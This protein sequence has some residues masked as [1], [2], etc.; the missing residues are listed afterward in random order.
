MAK[1]LEGLK[2]LDLSR[3]LAGPW[4]T[5]LLADMG[6][7]VWKVEKPGDGDDTRAWGPPYVEAADGMSRESAYFLCANRGKHSLAIDIA[8]PEGSALVARLAARADVLIENF[9]VGGLKRY[10]LDY[11]TLSAANPRLIY[12]SITGFGQDG[13]YAQRPGYDFVIQGMGGLMSVTGEAQGEPMKAGVAIVDVFTGLY[14]A[15]A[16]QAALLQRER[17]GRG[18]QIDIALLDV[19]VATLAN[20]AL[21]HLTT[22]KNPS[23]F[24][25][26]HPNIVP[27]QAFRTQDGSLTVAVGNDGQ[28]RRLAEVLGR[29]DW[30][31]DP[32][33]A[34]NEARVAHR[35]ALVSLIQTAFDTGPTDV[36]LGKLESAGVPAGAVN[37]L[38]EV[39]DDPQVRHRGLHISP[40]HDSLGHAPGIRCPIR[41]S[42]AETNQEVGAPPL[43]RHTREILQAELGLE[44]NELDQLGA[45]GAI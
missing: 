38:G 9:K 30:G 24:G 25:N 37:T 2:V 41:F 27:Y 39:F 31:A 14:A 22:G 10:G 15:N 18:Q 5:Q 17:S 11:A 35:D 6:A 12:C 4:A 1:A 42:D 43:G 45:V 3:V 7:S 16:I 26:A 21:N 34:T 20:Q 28:F 33:Y 8:T 36:W 40:R 19:Q 23:R 44:D 29:P 13:P 32:H